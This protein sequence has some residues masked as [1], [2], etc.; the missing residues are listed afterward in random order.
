MWH[1]I[2]TELCEQVSIKD[3]QIIFFSPQKTAVLQERCTKYGGMFP[4]NIE[5]HKNQ[6]QE[7][8]VPITD[9][10]LLCFQHILRD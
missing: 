4:L 2:L 9:Q 6:F 5:L 7:N 8:L 10:M 3:Q 1:S